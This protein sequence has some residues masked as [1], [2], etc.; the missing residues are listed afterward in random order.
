MRFDVEKELGTVRKILEPGL[1]IGCSIG[2]PESPDVT[3]IP[4]S[5]IE[6]CSIDCQSGGQLW[7]MDIF[8]DESTWLAVRAIHDPDGV[9]A[10]I[11]YEQSLFFI[12]DDLDR[13][14]QARVL[15]GN[16]SDELAMLVPC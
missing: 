3:S 4:V 7:L 1:L 2:E 10:T 11:A 14:D 6:P 16:A 5:D 12:K 9:G 13:L 8:G 15:V